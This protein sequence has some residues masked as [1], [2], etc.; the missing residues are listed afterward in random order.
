MSNRCVMK[1]QLNRQLENTPMIMEQNW[2]IF[3]HNWLL[4]NLDENFLS[5]VPFTSAEGH[6]PDFKEE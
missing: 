4:L 2:G 3:L 6:T 5:G 1:V